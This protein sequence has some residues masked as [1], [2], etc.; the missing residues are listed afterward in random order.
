MK[1]G[2]R[3]ALVALFVRLILG[4]AQAE[5]ASVVLK[6]H[7]L[8][9]SGTMDASMLTGLTKQD[10]TTVSKIRFSSSGGLTQYS[11]PIARL[12]SQS[13]KQIS[14]HDMCGSACL[15]VLVIRKRVTI[16]PDTVVL[17]HNTPSG[18]ALT[19]RSYPEISKFLTGL[20]NMEKGWLKEN[21]VDSRILLFSESAVSPICVAAPKDGYGP[22]AATRLITLVRFDV[23]APRNTTLSDMG[24]NS[25]KNWQQNTSSVLRIMRA[26][27]PKANL[28]R[29]RPADE[30]AI[31]SADKM[32]QFLSRVRTCG[33][34][35]R[36]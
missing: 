29:L 23:W 6:D 36:S 1:A 2:Q 14:I 11:V 19:T 10:W 20:G 26:K 16:E 25:A 4:P 24:I 22:D 5:P 18:Q 3:V 12:L 34:A 27:F 21:G 17:L 30:P 8:N 28:A 15:D 9:I 33:T 7:T 32:I 13:A 31:P 35:K